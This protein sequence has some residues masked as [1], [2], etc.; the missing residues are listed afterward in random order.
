M[1]RSRAITVSSLLAAAMGVYVC[2]LAA[3]VQALALRSSAVVAAQAQI[4]KS[5]NPTLSIQ[6][7]TAQIERPLEQNASQSIK[8]SSQDEEIVAASPVPRALFCALLSKYLSLS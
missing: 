4:K 8:L 5:A 1:L 7:A 6:V 3:D 2:L